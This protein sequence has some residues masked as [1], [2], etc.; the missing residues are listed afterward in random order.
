M[1]V[2]VIVFVYDILRGGQKRF[3]QLL[4]VI[5]GEK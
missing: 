4:M 5:C 1:L 3:G 2:F